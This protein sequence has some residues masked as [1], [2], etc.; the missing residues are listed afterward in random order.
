MTTTTTTTNYCDKSDDCST[1]SRVR[2]SLHPSFRHTKHL[3][4]RL[5]LHSQGLAFILDY[6]NMGLE[7][8]IWRGN[9]NL[10]LTATKQAVKKVK[11]N[12]A[13]HWNPI[14]LRWGSNEE[15]YWL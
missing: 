10:R 8:K 13:L 14:A 6:D 12:I 3:G 4:K 11:A 9:A 2:S 7:V 1:R 5:S 15:L